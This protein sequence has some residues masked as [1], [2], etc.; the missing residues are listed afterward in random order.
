M[1]REKSRHVF[2][3]IRHGI[4][5]TAPESPRRVQVGEEEIAVLQGIGASLREG[6]E[7]GG[8]LPGGHLSG[9]HRGPFKSYLLQG[10]E[11]N[12]LLNRDPAIPY[13]PI[14][15]RSLLFTK[16]SP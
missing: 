7:P 8:H 1:I 4:H 9:G 15:F 3:R 12:I 2:V 14:P 13:N 16:D 10:T 6:F 5:A 11:H